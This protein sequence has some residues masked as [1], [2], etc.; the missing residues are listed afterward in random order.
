MNFRVFVIMDINEK[1]Y[2]IDVRFEEEFEVIFYLNKLKNVF[3]KC[4]L[5]ILFYNFFIKL[6]LLIMKMLLKDDLF[7]ILIF[8][9]YFLN[10]LL[11]Y[12]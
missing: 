4:N 7:Y 8:F 6:L 2:V 12:Y 5:L 10:R 11:L 3:V 9:R 1:F